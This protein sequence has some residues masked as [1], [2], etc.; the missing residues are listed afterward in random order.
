MYIYIYIRAKFSLRE[1]IQTK[2]HKTDN[3][4]PINFSCNTNWSFEVYL[5]HPRPIRIIVK[6]F[7]RFPHQFRKPFITTV[8]AIPGKIGKK[9][10]ITFLKYNKFFKIGPN[11]QF[12]FFFFFLR[13]KV[14]RISLS[15]TW[16]DKK[17]V[18]FKIRRTRQDGALKWEING[19]NIF[20]TFYILW[21]LLTKVCDKRDYNMMMMF[22][23]L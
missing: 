2:L 3:S 19:L 11:F 14:E 1:T 7:D 22:L 17:R 5:V 23:L 10:Y 15:M 8:S 12:F 18:F 13:R 4:F 20:V 9:Y 21:A 16:K 6:R